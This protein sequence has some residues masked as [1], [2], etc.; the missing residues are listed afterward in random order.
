MKYKPLDLKKVKF[1]SE[2]KECKV[3]IKNFAK[4]PQ[5]NIL[6]KNFIDYLPDILKAN[7]FKNLID[8]IIISYQKQKPIIFAMGAHVIKCGLNPILIELMKKKNYYNN[9]IKW[10]WT[11][12]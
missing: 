10:C 3:N 12:S 4:Q 7:D 2:N 11:Y 8:D 5:K 6:L 9:S 1:S